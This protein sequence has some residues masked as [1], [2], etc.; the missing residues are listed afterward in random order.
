MSDGRLGKKFGVRNVLNIVNVFNTELE[1]YPNQQL[2]R[3][4]FNPL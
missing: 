2:I 4:P 1:N 3:T